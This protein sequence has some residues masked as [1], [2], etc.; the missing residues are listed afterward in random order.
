MSGALCV[1]LASAAPVLAINISPGGIYTSRVGSG[2]LTS[3]VDTA[4]ASNGVPGYTYA[5]TYVS[6]NSFTISAPS[7]AATV[8]STTLPGSMYRSGTYRCT[9]TDSLG[10][11][12][13]GDV[14]IEMESL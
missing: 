2:S 3:A 14:L 11:T 7:S 8:F 12:A 5:W 6:G 9:V 1:L 13:R 4:T 10:A